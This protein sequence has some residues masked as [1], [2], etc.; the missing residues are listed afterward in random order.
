MTPPMDA[1]S[2]TSWKV[3]T[4][5]VSVTPREE[6]NKSTNV[7]VVVSE[8]WPAHTQLHI[9]SS[10]SVNMVMITNSLIC[11]HV[12]CRGSWV[13]VG[14]HG[15]RFASPSPVKVAQLNTYS[16]EKLLRDAQRES[17][18]SFHV[19]SPLSS[20]QRWGHSHEPFHC[21]TGNILMTAISSQCRARNWVWQGHRVSA[22]ST[23]L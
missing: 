10:V 2:C 8:M 14:A 9:M 4:K 16:L 13:D 15:H 22:C 23:S 7:H 6:P 20:R 1:E 11:V 3:K 12:V 17:G 21:S 19:D 18:S 5:S